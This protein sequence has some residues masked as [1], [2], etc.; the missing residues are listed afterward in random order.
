MILLLYVI[1]VCVWKRMYS[2]F[3]LVLL[4]NSL[5]SCSLGIADRCIHPHA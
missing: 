2:A 1:T 4:A 5:M 3:F